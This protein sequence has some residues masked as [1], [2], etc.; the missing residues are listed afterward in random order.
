MDHVIERFLGCGVQTPSSRARGGMLADDATPD[1]L[2][3]IEPAAVV[4]DSARR[5]CLGCRDI[6]DRT[7]S[8]ASSIGCASSP[9]GH[10]PRRGRRPGSRGDAPQAV[11]PVVERFLAAVAAGGVRVGE[12]DLVRL[13]AEGAAAAR[14]G[15]PLAD[16][17]RRLPE[18][19]VGRLGSRAADRACPEPDACW[20]RS[21]AALLRAGD[22]IAA[23]LADGY[24][25][26]RAGPRVDRGRDAPGDP[27]G[28]A[29]ARRRPMRRGPRDCSRRVDAR[30]L[31]PRLDYHVLVDPARAEPGWLLAHAG[32]GAGAAAGPRPGTTTTPGGGAG[33]GRGGHRGITMAR[34]RGRS[35][36]S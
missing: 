23:A 27:R 32:R 2:P 26:R 20:A 5:C 18:H 28:A 31:R 17:H 1:M 8:P 9:A 14:Q 34:R 25:R 13:R 11:E 19:R 6:G 3:T 10:R 7:T 12:A 36:T 24:H 15:R 16:A 21:G 30:G 22:D 35:V 4:A 29:G 33:R